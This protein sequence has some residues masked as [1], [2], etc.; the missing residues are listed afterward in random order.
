MGLRTAKVHLYDLGGTLATTFTVAPAHAG[1]AK[2]AYYTDVDD[3]SLW[4]H[5]DT[6][7]FRCEMA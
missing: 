6:G 1:G 7:R 2:D 5:S 3:T 4:I